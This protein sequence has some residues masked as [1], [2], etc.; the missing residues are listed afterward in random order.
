[1][2]APVRV[3]NSARFARRQRLL[4]K[5]G[6]ATVRDVLG[7]YP[8]RYNDFS[9]V[10]EIRRARIGE[11]CSVFGTVLE[12]SFKQPRPRLKIV[13]VV[14]RDSTGMLYASW[15]NQPWLKTTFK[16]G[17]QA[18]LLGKVEHSY[19][20]KRMA[21][22]LFTVLDQDEAGGLHEGGE[23]EG[24][25]SGRILPVYHACAGLPTAQVA[26][27][28]NEALEATEGLYDPLPAACRARL[29]LMPL[30]AALRHI[31]RPATMEQRRE[32]RR[33]LAFDE[34]FFLMLSLK[35]KRAAAQKG[36]A[37]YAHRADGPALARLGSLLP[38]DL[39]DDQRQ[40]IATLLERMCEQ[41]QMN[42]L[43]V[44]DV[45]SGKTVIAAHALAVAYDSGFQAAMM[46]PTEVLVQQYVL[47]VGPLLD[48]L[49]VPW[50][51][52]TSSTPASARRKAA[53]QLADGTLSV[54]FG[55]Q[56]LLEPDITFK[57]LS[58][59][60]IDEQHRFGVSQRD[61]LRAKGAGCDLLM[62]TATPIPRSLAQVLYGDLQPTY[63]RTRHQS[64]TTVTKLLDRSQVGIA[65]DAV[66]KA[67]AQG[68]Q[69][70]VVCPLIAQP[71]LQ[72]DGPE[73]AGDIEGSFDSDARL[74]DT[75]TDLAELEGDEGLRAVEREVGFLARRV[76]PDLRVGLMSSRLSAEDKRTAMDQFRA[77]E[78]DVLVST[79]VVEVGVDVPNATVMIVEDA[80]RFGL[81]QLHQLRGRIGRGSAEGAM[82]LVTKTRDDEALRRLRLLEHVSDG[83]ELAEHDLRLRH[84][85]DVLGSRQHG[86]GSLRL[87]RVLDDADLVAAADLE[88]EA[89]LRDDP[90]L[91][92]SRHWHVAHE[93]AM[94]VGRAPEDDTGGAFGHA[95][96]VAGGA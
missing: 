92:A 13:E 43:L 11:K 20:F 53:G 2:D 59:V 55:T 84:E 15:F 82:F 42:Q 38:F 72:D 57:Q 35:L 69:A 34:V 4:E 48:A 78:L 80:D 3:L 7:H 1:M 28:V 6:L 32:A 95:G 70:Y 76:F 86:V 19:G 17:T 31:H 66:R 67:A 9:Q 64:V 24:G 83:F 12:V 68:N 87:I 22:P 50:A 46:A 58:L 75:F 51:S 23:P 74:I 40:T 18:F 49:L 61:A 45:G 39:T 33:R 90:C 65:Y 14:L 36:I 10:T 89:L 94:R 63:L 81:S 85:G 62:M 93:L 73:G 52:L 16:V 25:Q 8:F 44:G 29:K 21:S 27:V 60:V 37:P 88:T 79:T 41:R 77:G 47:K 30:G 71:G 91:A 56:A 26:R 96:H 54:V 5:L